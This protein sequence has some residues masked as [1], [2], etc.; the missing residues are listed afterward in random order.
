MTLESLGSA[1]STFSPEALATEWLLG[2]AILLTLVACRVGG[3]VFAIDG[4]LVGVPVRMRVALVVIIAGVLLP[5]VRLET[6]VGSSGSSAAAWTVAFAAGREW[7]FGMIIGATVQLLITGIQLA[8]ELIASSTGMQLAQVADPSTGQPVPQWSRLFGLLVTALLFA[9]GGHRMLIDALLS[10]FDRTSPDLSTMGQPIAAFIVQ[11]L[12]T[13]IEAGIRVAAPVVACVL[14]TNVM[15]AVVSRAIPQLN[16]LAVGMNLN[17][18]AA[19]VVIALTVGSAGL[20][21]ESELARS[22]AELRT[23]GR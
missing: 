2:K 15:V 21:F 22:I 18:L 8:G 16:V 19:L 23:L 14:L 11:H 20:V 4:L 12:A 1:L 17:L 13:G 3:L 5:N 7:V 9:A 10:S 6:L